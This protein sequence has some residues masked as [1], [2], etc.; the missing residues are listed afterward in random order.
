VEN[1]MTTKR[2]SDEETI[3]LRRL[4]EI[5]KVRKVMLLYSH[6]MDM[7]DWDAMAQ[8]YADD[9]VGEWGVY[10][11]W[12]GRAQIHR[13]LV[14]G[15]LGRLP[16]DGFHCTTNVWV[17]LTSPR[18]AISRCY[19]IDVW[20]SDVLGPVSHAGY[21]ENPV[22]MYAVYDNDYEK[23]GADWLIA[24][25]TIGMIWPKRI[26]PEAFPRDMAALAI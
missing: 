1:A 4:L 24:R 17:E 2:L 16:Y 7:R 13:Q 18:T 19:L 22:L 5:E 23:V 6:L 9:A 20:P 15:H 8:L 25:S 3:A 10:G 26:V 14:D 21:P 11:T 12:Q